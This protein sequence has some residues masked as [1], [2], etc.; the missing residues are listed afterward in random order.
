MEHGACRGA[1][2]EAAGAAD[3]DLVLVAEVIPFIDAQKLPER[4]VEVLVNQ[5][6]VAQWGFDRRR[7][8]ERAARIPREVVSGDGVVRID[9]RFPAL[10]VCRWNSASAK[11]GG[12]S[13][14]SW[15]CGGWRQRRRSRARPAVVRPRWSK[16]LGPEGAAMRRDGWLAGIGKLQAE[17]DRRDWVAI[18]ATRRLPWRA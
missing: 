12:R 18:P 14:C 17:A 10:L 1:H 5:T 13:H 4:H 11:T 3:G 7:I 16:L 6:P 9:F 15:S 2:R 8:A